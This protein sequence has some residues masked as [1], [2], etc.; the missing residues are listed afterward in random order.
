M[1]TENTIISRIAIGGSV[2]DDHNRCHPEWHFHDEDLNEEISKLG[3]KY[4]KKCNFWKEFG[5]IEEELIA[6]QTYLDSNHEFIESYYGY[7]LGNLLVNHY[8]PDSWWVLNPETGKHMLLIQEEF[9]SLLVDVFRA[10]EEV[11]ARLY[12]NIGLATIFEEIS[13]S[14]YY[15]YRLEK[16]ST[17]QE[18]MFD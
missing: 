3:K 10:M 7:S 9:R 4:K 17:E 14:R 6:S 18:C 15:H 12:E 5:K 11:S 2:D 8:Y 1:T 13:R 16:G